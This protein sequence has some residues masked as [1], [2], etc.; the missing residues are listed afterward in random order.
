MRGG[1]VLDVRSTMPNAIRELNDLQKKVAKPATN[2]AL[3]ITAKRIRTLARRTAAEILDFLPQKYLTPRIHL[4]KSNFRTLTAYLIALTLPLSLYRVY[5]EKGANK[6]PGAFVAKMQS[7]RTSIYT[8]RATARAKI[9]PVSGKW[10]QLP[11]DEELIE[12]KPVLE[13]RFNYYM[14]RFAPR[15]FRKQFDQQLA[16][17]AEKLQAKNNRKGKKR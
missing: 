16:W 13:A 5:G 17:R 8:R 15:E 6:R 10:S 7:G 2:A 4:I 1:I 9:S 14:A 3:N 11:I 12:V